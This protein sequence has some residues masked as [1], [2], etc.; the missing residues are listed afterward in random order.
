MSSAL[1]YYPLNRRKMGR[2][3]V[4]GM[5]VVFRIVVGLALVL[6]MAGGG[7]KYSRRVRA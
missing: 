7:C 1:V 6:L 3:K 4:C 5:R 2:S